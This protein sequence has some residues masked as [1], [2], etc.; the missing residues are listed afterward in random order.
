MATDSKIRIRQLNSAIHSFTGFQESIP[1]ES[2][3]Q[4]EISTQTG[5]AYLML[6][7]VGAALKEFY[8]A[9]KINPKYTPAYSELADYYRDNNK[10]EEARKILEQ[11]LK[12][13]PKSKSLK[14]RLNEL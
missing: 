13:N 10:P 2:V 9:I 6:D 14:R 12:K 7:Q 5:R 1:R 11:G 3:L 8:N 4:P